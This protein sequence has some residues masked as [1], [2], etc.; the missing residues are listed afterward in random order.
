MD[1]GARSVL[2]RNVKIGLICSNATNRTLDVL[3]RNTNAEFLDTKYVME[4]GTYVKRLEAEGVEVRFPNQADRDEVHRVIY[5]E[6]C[7]NDIRDESWTRLGAEGCRSVVLGCTELPQLLPAIRSRLLPLRA[8]GPPFR[9]VGVF[10][11]P[12]KAGSV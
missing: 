3:R 5:E 12:L 7:V 8:G 10:R 9:R 1:R 4:A 2:N 6:L 11:R